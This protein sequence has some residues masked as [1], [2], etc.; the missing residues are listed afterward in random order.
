MTFHLD[1]HQLRARY[2]GRPHYSDRLGLGHYVYG[3]TSTTTG[4]GLGIRTEVPLEERK[5]KASLSYLRGLQQP[6]YY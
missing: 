1:I 3:T 5:K 4:R 6:R 2:E